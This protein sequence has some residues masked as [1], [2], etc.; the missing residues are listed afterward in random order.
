MN[1]SVLSLALGTTCI[2]LAPIFAKYCDLSPAQIGM[3]RCG[4]AGIILFFYLI[5]TGHSHSI[6][7]DR[8]FFSITF[9][10]G[11]LFACDLFVWHNSIKYIGPGMATIFGN[12]QVFYL[13]LLGLLLYGEKLTFKKIFIFIGAFFGVVLILTGQKEFYPTDHFISG[14]IFG[15]STG[16]FYALYTTSLKRAN[17]MSANYGTLK[18][19][20]FASL[21][22]GVWLY[23]FGL[24][25]SHP[26]GQ[27]IPNIAPVAGLVFLCQILGWG[28]ITFGLKSV[29]LFLSGLIIL[30]QPVI[31]KIL[32]TFIFD[33]PTGILEWIGGLI[34]LVCIYLGSRLRNLESTV[35]IKT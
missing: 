27:L 8:K 11:F 22:T 3:Y 30:L 32:A 28:L 23:L 29:P 6:P 16:L 15:L 21:W 17:M 2:G 33:E 18:I 24:F 26:H 19:I 5:I 20:C 1:S 14:T 7:R 13:M 12:T 9:I 4:F 34:L 25:E 31:A 10:A 35:N